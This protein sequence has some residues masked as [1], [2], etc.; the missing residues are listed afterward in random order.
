MA[1]FL[2]LGLG[3]G[4]WIATVGAAQQS[5]PGDLLY[6]VVRVDEMTR[7]GLAAAVGATGTETKMRV[8][9]AKRRAEETKKLVSQ[10][11]RGEISERTEIGGFEPF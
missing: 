1:V 4:S 6:T 11:L 2:I 9:F 7:A 10:N 5:M 8:G 3:T